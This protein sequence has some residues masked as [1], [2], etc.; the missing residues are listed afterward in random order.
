M[1]GTPPDGLEGHAEAPGDRAR[2]GRGERGERKRFPVFFFF[3]FQVFFGLLSFL[4]SLFLSFLLSLSFFVAALSSHASVLFPFFQKNR[5]KSNNQSKTKQ[6]KKQKQKVLSRASGQEK[7]TEAYFGLNLISDPRGRNTILSHATASREWKWVR[8]A[9]APA[10]SQAA[11]KAGFEGAIRPSAEAA[12]EALARA[13]D[14]KSKSSPSEKEGAA[15][16][17]ASV[18]VNVDDLAAASVQL[19]RKERDDDMRL[20]FFSLPAPLSLSIHPH[21]R[22]DATY[23]CCPLRPR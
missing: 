4:F 10:F 20:S 14:E 19:K 15:A 1:R 7:S 21:S 5:P 12:A 8:K 16:A 17:A 2:P 6:N 9:V 3:L 22:S 11:M 23:R 13:C 18:S